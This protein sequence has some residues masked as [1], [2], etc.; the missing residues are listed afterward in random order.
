MEVYL[1]TPEVYVSHLEALRKRGGLVMFGGRSAHTFEQYGM[2]LQCEGFDPEAHGCEPLPC[3]TAVP[4]KPVVSAAVSD[5]LLDANAKI[6]ELED[7]L[8]KG[9]SGDLAKELSDLEGKFEDLCFGKIRDMVCAVEEAGTVADGGWGVIR[10]GVGAGENLWYCRPDP[11][12]DVAFV[13]CADDDPAELETEGWVAWVSPEHW[14]S[15]AKD[16]GLAVEAE[17]AT[18]LA[19]IQATLKAALS[20]LEESGKLNA[21]LKAKNDELHAKVK[22]LTATKPKAGGK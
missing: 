7:L 14:A 8:A 16:L 15:M 4:S 11:N 19:D 20:D 22:E 18:E 2:I 10:S 12:G 21:E 9:E 6:A 17:V 5:A 3:D 13:M 1:L